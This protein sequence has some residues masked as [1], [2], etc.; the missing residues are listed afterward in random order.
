MCIYIYTYVL[1]G[2]SS[3]FEV[4]A[5][6]RRRSLHQFPDLPVAVLRVWGA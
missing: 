6:V 2:A 4:T 1:R 3:G 5:G